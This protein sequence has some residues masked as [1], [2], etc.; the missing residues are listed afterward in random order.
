[1]I[2]LALS[3]FIQPI[4][5][6]AADRTLPLTIESTITS[7]PTGSTLPVKTF[8]GS[9]DGVTRIAVVGKN[10]LLYHSVLTS[11]APAVCK[12]TA[13]KAARNGFPKEVSFPINFYFGEIQSDLNIYV[14]T[15]DPTTPTTASLELKTKGGS[16]E[17][18]ILFTLLNNPKCS[19][20]GSI[21]T[22]IDSTT[23]SVYA[24]KS[25]N[26]Q[27]AEI[28]SGILDR[29]FI[30]TTITGTTGLTV[31]YTPPK[32]YGNNGGN[33]GGGDTRTAQTTTLTISN[34]NTYAFVN[35][36]TVLNPKGGDGLGALSFKLNPGFSPTCQLNADPLNP[37]HPTLISSRSGFCSIT[38]T[39]AGDTQYKPQNSQ[40]IVWTINPIPQPNLVITNILSGDGT[41]HA[42]L[43]TYTVISTNSGG[44]SI[45][46]PYGIL[47][48]I[49]TSDSA[50][51]T[52]TNN[53]I[54]AQNTGTCSVTAKMNSNGIYA[55]VSSSPQIFKF[56]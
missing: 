7:A 46:T 2:T 11:R 23:C 34:L 40:P 24:T 19:L 31:Y 53:R 47:Y 6:E 33:N 16:G 36:T 43:Q 8:G 30:K 18:K 45:N 25:G 51:C 21:L 52:L 54:S 27:Y 4:N 3:G 28:S 50:G 55:D 1:M 38:V 37:D 10:C 39:K 48:F 20:I 35:D 49:V 17:G 42:S 15:T 13:I 29:N 12:V 14:D 44:T 5:S 41:I 22:A 32:Y 9:G 26:K 56:S